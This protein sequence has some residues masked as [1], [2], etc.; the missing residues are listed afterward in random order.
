MTKNEL[1]VC[2]IFYSIS[3]EG[4]TIGIPAVFLRLSKCNFSCSWTTN[5][6]IQ[7]C[8]TQ[9]AKSSGKIMD[10]FKITNEIVKQV[11][12][13]GGNKFIIIFTGGEPTLQ[14]KQLYEYLST[15]LISPSPEYFTSGVDFIDIESNGTLPILPPKEFRRWFQFFRHYVVSPKPETP[16]NNLKILSK[17]KNVYFKFVYDGS[18]INFIKNSIM[19]MEVI[20][21]DHIYLMSA[22]TTYEELHDL[23]LE[24]IELCKNY[25]FMF[26]P[27]LQSYLWGKKRG[28]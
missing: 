22:G 1:N 2:E 8:D 7:Y 5:G 13:V 14:A 4:P 10:F 20:K 23:D 21:R 12:K 3:G 27:R 6:K 25:G 9:Y 16:I 19:E 18:N 28:V 26:T 11:K 24:T 15:P 17:I